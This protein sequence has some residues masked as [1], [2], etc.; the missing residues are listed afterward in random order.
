MDITGTGTGTAASTKTLGE[1]N[2]TMRR[3]WYVH[4]VAQV[5]VDKNKEKK[6]VR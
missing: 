2:R 1:N 4:E 3:R 5:S 6:N